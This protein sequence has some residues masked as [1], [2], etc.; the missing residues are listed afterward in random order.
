MVM[1]VPDEAQSAHTSGNTAHVP[2]ENNIEEMQAYT[3]NSLTS[4]KT[5]LPSYFQIL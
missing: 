2:E 5:S 3:T 4:N 1:K